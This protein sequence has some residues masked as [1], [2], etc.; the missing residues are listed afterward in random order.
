MVSPDVRVGMMNTKA[1][2]EAIAKETCSYL[3]PES[4]YIESALTKKIAEALESFAA[5]AVKEAELKWIRDDHPYI[6]E[7]ISEARNEAI[8]QAVEVINELREE[9]ET[10]LRTAIARIRFL[11]STGGK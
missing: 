1:R 11:K 8:D 6:T 2:A 3:K 5:E 10:D 4:Q 7:K 9:G